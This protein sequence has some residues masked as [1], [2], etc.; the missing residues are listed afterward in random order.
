MPVRGVRSSWEVLARNTL[1]ARL[2]ASAISA[3]S[4]AS[5]AAWASSVLAIS[6]VASACLRPVMSTTTAPTARGF[7]SSP[8]MGKKESMK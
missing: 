1:L 3:S 6:S 7:P 4:S 8:K 5:K 2:A